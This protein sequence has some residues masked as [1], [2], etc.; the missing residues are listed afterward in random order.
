[1]CRDGQWL[2]IAK[3][4]TKLCPVNNLELYLSWSGINRENSKFLFRNLSK[5][6]GSYRLRS[7]KKPITYTRMRELLIDAFKEFVPDIKKYGL[8]SLRSGGATASANSGIPDRLFKRHGKWK[9][10]SA[11]DGHVKDMVENRLSVSLNLGI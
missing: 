3:T 5:V 1:M 10:E 11:K 8:H 4:G 2:I 6:E 9:S 7:V